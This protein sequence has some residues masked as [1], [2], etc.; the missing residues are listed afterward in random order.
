[1]NSTEWHM[2]HFGQ[3]FCTTVCNHIILLN[4]K[5]QIAIWNTEL[6]HFEYVQR[7]MWFVPCSE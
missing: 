6:Y 7:R 5:Y 1:M 4:G 2:N 3:W